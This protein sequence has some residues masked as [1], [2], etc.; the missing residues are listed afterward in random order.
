[1]LGH[2]EP[3]KR[4]FR[5]LGIAL[6]LISLGG[7]VGICPGNGPYPC[8]CRRRIAPVWYGYFP[9]CWR[10]WPD[11]AGRMSNVAAPPC[12]FQEPALPTNSSSKEAPSPEIVPTPRGTAPASAAASP[13]ATEKAATPENIQSGQPAPMPEGG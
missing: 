8:H 6:L 7:C 12:Q 1:M 2:R 11:P 10:P 4:R 5:A 13:P 9:T 3:K